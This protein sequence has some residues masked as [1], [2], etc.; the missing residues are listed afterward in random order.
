M[1]IIAPNPAM[2]SPKAEAHAA[3][4][5]LLEILFDVSSYSES[6]MATRHSVR[7]GGCDFDI[8]KFMLLGERG[9]GKPIRLALFAGIDDHGSLDG[10]AAITACCCRPSCAR[11][12]RGITRFSPTRW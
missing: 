6:L 3:A 8:P 7:V 4:G 2:L 11:P 10:I 1:T 9:G 5:D 12:W